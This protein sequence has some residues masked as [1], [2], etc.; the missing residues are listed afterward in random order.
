MAASYF[1]VALIAGWCGTPYPKR[2][3]FP[4]PFPPIPGPGPDPICPVCGSILGAMGGVIIHGIVAWLFPNEINVTS[5]LVSGFIGG[6]LLNDL[7]GSVMP[8]K[9]K[10]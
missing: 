6:R 5:A 9:M 10:Q 8:G 4:W 1:I 3:R 2:W 7:A